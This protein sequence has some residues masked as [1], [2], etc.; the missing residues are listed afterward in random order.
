MHYR[1][2]DT[3]LVLVLLWLL[4]APVLAQ[5]PPPDDSFARYEGVF[6]LPSG[7]AIVLTTTGVIAELARPVFIDWDA[8]RAGQLVVAAEDSLVSP[9]VGDPQAPSQAEFRIERAADGGAGP[10]P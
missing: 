6:R 4:A 1:Y 3:I 7:R 5:A 8:N 2:S 10:P 9:A